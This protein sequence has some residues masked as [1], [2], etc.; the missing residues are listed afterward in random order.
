MKLGFFTDPHYGSDRPDVKNR[1]YSQSLRK[2]G[3]AYAHFA[4][5]KCELVIC[6]GD[7]I[8]R[9]KNH[10]DEIAHLRQAAEVIDASGIRTLCVM[11]NHDAFT[12]TPEE[13]YEILGAAHRPQDLSVGGRNLIF[14]DACYY[15]D[16]THYIVGDDRWEDTFCPCAAALEQ[17]LR[18]LQGDTYLFLHQNVDPTL[19]ENHRLFNDAQLR[20]IFES[21]SIVKT[22]FQGH[23]HPGNRCIH[24]GIQYVTF[25]AMSDG[26]DAFWTVE[27]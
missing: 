8:D 9:E 15:S 1:V 7:L 22:V 19:P 27:I 11:G 18:T 12:F 21:S 23:Y 14:L 20:K 26:E 25:S 6:L 16:G 10:A 5:E 17:K 3:E 13:F 24:N 4:A 2:M